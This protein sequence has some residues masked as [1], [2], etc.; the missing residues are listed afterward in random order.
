MDSLTPNTILIHSIPF[1]AIAGYLKYPTQIRINSK[2]LYIISIIHN[3]VLI[4]FSAWTFLSLMYILYTDGIV[5][6]SNYYFENPF[7]DK[8]IFCFYLSKYYEFIDTFLLYLNGK[9]PIFL[10]KYHHVGAVLSWH[11]MYIYKV[12][13][14]G[15]AT[16]LNSIVHTIMYSYYLGCL[17]KINQVRF[18]K[19][20]IT[21]MQ[22]CQFFILYINFYLYRP[23]I[24]TWFNYYIIIFFATYGVG[25]IGL[26]LSFYYK[27][28][29]MKIK[30]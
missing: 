17:L 1:I 6:Q 3:T 7:F 23:P 9:T 28:Y 27:N 10:Q 22:L 21:S 26:F 12:D 15:M 29:V 16:L 18:L 4:A 24:E 30:V 2:A 8:I 14:V 20:Y 25:V 11:L 13:V 19:Q 5:F